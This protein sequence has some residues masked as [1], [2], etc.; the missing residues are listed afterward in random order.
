MFILYVIL[1]PYSIERLLA[2]AQ[3][4]MGVVLKVHQRSS[5]HANSATFYFRICLVFLTT[6]LRLLSGK[7]RAS[8]IDFK[9]EG[10][11]NTE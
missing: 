5:A 11:W 10:P 8:E 7:N 9:V 1:W 3:A 2:D 4:N 6:F